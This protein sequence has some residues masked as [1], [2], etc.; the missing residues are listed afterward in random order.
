MAGGELEMFLSLDFFADVD[1]CLG[2]T[3]RCSSEAPQVDRPGGTPGA[4][5]E[6]LAIDVRDFVHYAAPLISPFTNHV[7]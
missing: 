2:V 4:L 6:V 1:S 7:S 5:S 3:I